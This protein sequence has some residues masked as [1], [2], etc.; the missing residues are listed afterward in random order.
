M[1]YTADTT[2]IASETIFTRFG[3]GVA[4]VLETM[5]KTLGRQEEFDRAFKM[6]DAQLK[7]LGVQREDIAKHV[8]RDIY[9][10]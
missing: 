6:S 8:F 2:A 1:A 9:Y 7:A 10:I 3:H 5:G 4:N